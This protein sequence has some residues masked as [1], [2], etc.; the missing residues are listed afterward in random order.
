M[1]S[2]I[3]QQCFGKVRY[4]MFPL[5]CSYET[6]NGIKAEEQGS[7]RSVGEPAEPGTVAQG[8]YSYTDPDGNLIQLTYTADENGFVPQ[9]AHLP[10]S[11]PIPPEI[12]AALEKNAAE[13]AAQ[14]AGVISPSFHHFF[15]SAYRRHH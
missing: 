9:G 2:N 1:L 14:N 13:E 10:T 7:Q 6:G 15:R 4:H 8:S 12:L 3:L 5:C 11:P